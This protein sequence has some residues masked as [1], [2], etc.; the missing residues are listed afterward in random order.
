MFISRLF[1]IVSLLLLSLNARDIKPLFRLHA[2]G[3]VTDFVIDGFELYASTDM[4]SIDIF[5]IRTRKMIRQI[6][7]E[8]LKDFKG[9]LIPAKVFSVDRHNGKTLIVSASADGYRDVWVHDGRELQNI[10]TPAD[11][12]VIQEAR[13]IDD[14]KILFGTL[15]YDVILYDTQEKYQ[16][17]KHH[18]AQGS[19]SDIDLSADHT[20]MITADESGEVTL[21]D[22]KTSEVLEVFST[23]NVDK[24]YK[25]AYRNGTVI[26][27][28]QDRRVGVYPKDGEPY[29]I[30]SDFLVYCAGLSPDGSIG[31]YASGVDNDLQTFDVRN[32]KKRDRLIGHFATLTT[33]HFLN[34]NELFSAGDENDIFFWSLRE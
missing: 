5:D 2:T 3:L 24:V 34:E 13:F 21:S 9:E 30:K 16:A 8:P 28:G 18:V 4:G 25:I 22:V 6:T 12:L 14:E 20:R 29:H 7:L 23:Q 31:V 32:G 26:T 19:F 15:D 33:I 11:K 27:A 1:L 17:Y 10:I